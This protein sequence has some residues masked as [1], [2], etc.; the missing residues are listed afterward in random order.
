[1]TVL[2]STWE[3][4]VFA[5]TGETQQQEL[6]GQPV[7]C[8]AAGP[9]ENTVAIVDGNR[10]CRR[11]G[12]GE[13]KTLVELDMGLACLVTAGRDIY[14]GTDDAKV[15]RIAE[16]AP[17]EQ[18]TGFD[19][20][21]GRDSWFA[22]SAVVDGRVVGPPLGVRSIAAT[23]DG[24]DLL[25]NVHVGGIP[26]SSDGGR[27][28]RPTIDINADVH[29]VAAHPAQPSSV[30]AAAATG[31]CISEDG[32]VTWAV[33]Q[34]GLHAPYCSAAAFWGESAI[35]AASTDHFAEF[36]V[37]YRWSQSSAEG[38]LEPVGAGIPS[39]TE[40]IVDTNCIATTSSTLAV[41]DQG[42]NLYVS[43]DGRLS[44]RTRGLPSPSS[45]RIL[46]SAG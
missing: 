19:T 46:P 7:R 25:A 26:R 35:V 24:Q 28:W 21:P 9:D 37:V 41:A 43:S 34:A 17:P 12:G 40:G 39:R 8:L 27:S 42:G 33:V 15:F 2:V 5:V 20:T 30:I 44:Y 31:F 32:G 45:V 14:V 38:R 22:G 29:E 36:G 16:G 10:I 11:S 3:E 23:A 13:W 6:A 18:L 1:M 4:G